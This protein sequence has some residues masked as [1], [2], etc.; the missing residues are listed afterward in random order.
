MGRILL[1]IQP[2]SKIYN[3]KLCRSA[4]GSGSECFEATDHFL[5]QFTT[6]T[7]KVMF[8]HNRERLYV[9]V[10]D[11]ENPCIRTAVLLQNA[12]GQRA[13]LGDKTVT[14]SPG[15]PFGVVQKRIDTI[16]RHFFSIRFGKDFGNRGLQCRDISPQTNK[17]I[18]GFG[19]DCSLTPGYRVFV[20]LFRMTFNLCAK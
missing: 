6:V 18:F 4:S 7:A 5:T 14:K 10:H 8:D 19:H 3:V 13:N 20:P 1:L 15:L 9:H 11:P 2:M 12:T 16:R 17:I